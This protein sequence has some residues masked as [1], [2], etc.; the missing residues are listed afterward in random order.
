MTAIPKRLRAIYCPMSEPT[1]YLLLL[2]QEPNYGYSIIQEASDLTGGEVVFSP[3]TLYG[4]IKKLLADGLIQLDHAEN[5]RKLYILTE[6]GEA[7]LKIEKRRILRLCTNAQGEA[8][9]D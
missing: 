5:R 6:L 1:F 3:G 8:Y 9:R 7:L 4:G 2:M